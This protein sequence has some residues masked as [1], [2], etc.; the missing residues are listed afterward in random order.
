MQTRI[1]A[2]QNKQQRHIFNIADMIIVGEK[3]GPLMPSPKYAGIIAMGEDIYCFDIVI[4]T[5]LGFDVNKI[6]LY[7]YLK[8]QNKIDGNLEIISNDARFNNKKVE[9]IKKENCINIE[10][11]SGWKNNIEL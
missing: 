2:M 1:G 3:Q 8:Q 4:A 6:P 5:I 9:K 10:P 7:K 11:S